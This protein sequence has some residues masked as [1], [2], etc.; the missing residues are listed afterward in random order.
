MWRASSATWMAITRSMIGCSD[1]PSRST[2]FWV[3][4]MGSSPARMPNQ[5][6]IGSGP[7]TS[8]INGCTPL[9]QPRHTGHIGADVVHHLLEHHGVVALFDRLAQ[10]V[11]VLR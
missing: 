2:F 10:A 11:A 9:Q 1:L 6:G 3:W 4:S 7:A 8:G 5:N